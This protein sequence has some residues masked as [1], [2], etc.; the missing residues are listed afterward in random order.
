MNQNTSNLLLIL[1]LA[2]LCAGVLFYLNSISGTLKKCCEQGT[3]PIDTGA[4]TITYPTNSIGAS[5][6]SLLSY[7]DGETVPLTYDPNVVSSGVFP[8]RAD[9]ATKNCTIRVNLKSND[10]DFQ[11]SVFPNQHNWFV[12]GVSAQ[13]WEFFSY[14]QGVADGNFNLQGSGMGTIEIY[15]NGSLAPSKSINIQLN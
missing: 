4:C 8:I 10:P 14:G 5:T 11:I 12:R 13:E 2:L 3:P 6:P 1:I 15:E 7:N 9:L